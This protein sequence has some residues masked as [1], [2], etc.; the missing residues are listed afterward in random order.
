MES[1]YKKPQRIA[2]LVCLILIALLYLVTLVL[3]CIQGD[4]AKVA[5][6]IALGCTLVLPLLAWVYIWCFGKIL[7]KHTIADFDL[8]GVPTDNTK[9][10]R[11]KKQ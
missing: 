7:H 1:K 11:E 3:T 5:L 6:R 9:N 2:A 8:F 4:W 10:K